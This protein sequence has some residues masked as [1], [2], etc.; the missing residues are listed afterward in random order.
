MLFNS[1]VF[2]VFFAVVVRLH[3]LPLAWRVKKLNLLLASYFSMPPGIRP[4]LH[5]SGCL[6]S[7]TGLPRA[8]L[9]PPDS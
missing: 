3:Y 2:I 9:G 4:W 1:T 7:L 5:C 8:F 6:P